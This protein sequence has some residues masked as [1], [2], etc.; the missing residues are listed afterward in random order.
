[1]PAAAGLAL[2]SARWMPALFGA[3]YRGGGPWLALVAARLP[4]VLSGSFSQAA[5]VACRREREALR[6]VGAML[7][8]AALVVPLATLWA[9]LSGAALAILA[10][11]LAGAAGG[12]QLLRAL[13]AAPHWTDGKVV[14]SLGTLAMA[15][16]CWASWPLPVGVVCV[17][18][19]A[20]YGLTWLAFLF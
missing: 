10:V 1:M 20:A 18:G 7:I 2:T 11:E 8:A 12:W 17:A 15:G 6:L 5:L 13:G 14:P 4:W 19:A 9:G 3:G 16:V